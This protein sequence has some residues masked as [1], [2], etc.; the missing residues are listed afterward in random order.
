M[1]ASDAAVGY[2]GAAGSSGP[3][4]YPYTFKAWSWDPALNSG[5]TV[6]PTQYVTLERV[7]LSS[8]QLISNF[9][10]DLTQAGSGLTSGRN[11]MG[12]FSA[13]GAQLGIS[14]GQ[15]ANWVS[16]GP[17]TIPL[18][19]PY[20]AAA[21]EYYIGLLCDGSAGPR[22]AGLGGAMERANL[23]LS[24]PNLRM[25]IVGGSLTAMPSNLPTPQTGYQAPW[26]GLS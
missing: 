3:T 5:N 19:T 23:G 20:S 14:A 16:V 1:K 22:F 12:L 4:P 17:K 15:E 26:M 11:L 18:V 25:A 13:A 8:A 9:H 6:P 2:G 24:S 10:V 21:G 7:A